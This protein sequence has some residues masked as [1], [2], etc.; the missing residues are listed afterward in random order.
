MRTPDPATA[1]ARLRRLARTL[2][3]TAARR[4]QLEAEAAALER[5]HAVLMA[6]RRRERLTRAT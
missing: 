5:E 6:E 1:A 3:P 4:A 2:P